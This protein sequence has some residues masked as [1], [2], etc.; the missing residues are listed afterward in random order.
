MKQT[1][2]Y[3][4]VSLDGFIAGPDGNLDWLNAVPP[5]QTGDYG[6]QDFLKSV[7]TIVMGR[8]TYDEII[9]FGIDWP[10]VG[11]DSY[12]VS[13]NEH[14]LIRSPDTYLLKGSIGDF[15]TELQQKA[16]KD[17]WLVG[18]GQLITSFIN[19]D[20]LDKMILTLIP[21]VIG[22]GIPLF[23]H[24]PMHTNW[25]LTQTA[26]FDTGVVSLTYEKIRENN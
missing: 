22:E 12:V 2:L 15:V 24:K 21:Q 8:K 23:A 7:G 26:T 5:P 17:I 9:G 20:L 1:V 18:G 13:N 25:R 19:E 6:Y 10:Y 16:S 11:I 14:L 4:A 3:I